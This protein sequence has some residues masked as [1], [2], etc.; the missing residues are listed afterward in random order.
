M[1]SQNNTSKP[2]YTGIIIQGENRGEKIGFPTINIS[3]KEKN[4][5]HGV[6][7]VTSTI[8]NKQHHGVANVGPA[9]TFNRET[10][11][12]EV[13]LLNTD[14]NFYN[15]KATVTFLEFIRPTKKFNTTDEL[16]NQIKADVEKAKQFFKENHV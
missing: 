6:Y 13:H 16:V 9:P 1:T 7:T 3:I 8:L 4:I 12:I 10:P 5:K 11:L 15:Q 2:S 14:E